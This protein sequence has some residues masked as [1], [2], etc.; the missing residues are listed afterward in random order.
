MGRGVFGEVLG[1]IGWEV[2]CVGEGGVVWIDD[3]KFILFL[4]MSI[5]FVFEFWK[6]VRGECDFWSTY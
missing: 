1:V 2:N 5:L 4:L 3:L 6:L